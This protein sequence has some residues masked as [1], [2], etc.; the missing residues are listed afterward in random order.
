MTCRLQ[1]IELENFRG[2]A[3]TRSLDLD[4]D[5]VL[6]RGDNGSGKTSLTDG[7]LWLLTGEL[8]HL[9]ERVKG[10][11]QTH[12]AIANRYSDGAS[13]VA[14]T[15]VTPQASWRFER[16]GNA[17]SS[18]LRG[19]RDGQPVE[20]EE[21]LAHA[22]GDGDLRDFRD[23]VGTWGVLRQDAIRSVL[24]TGGAALH[25]RM[26]SVIGLSEVSRFRAACR[27][28][29][30]AAAQTRRSAETVLAAAAK[31]L[32]A[33]RSAQRKGLP[34]AAANSSLLAV[35]LVESAAPVAEDLRVEVAGVASLEDLVELGRQVTLLRDLAAA[36]ADAQDSYV[37]SS[38]QRKDAVATVQ[39]EFNEAAKQA[40]E[41]ESTST[42]I[43][44]LAELALNLL[45]NQCPVCDQDIDQAAVRSKLQA[46]LERN[47]LRLVAAS[48]ARAALSALSRRLREAQATEQQVKRATEIRD[49]RLSTWLEALNAVGLIRMLRPPRADSARLLARRLD[50]LRAALQALYAEERATTELDEVRLAA[51]VTA[52]E[53][54]EVVAR[55]ALSTAADRERRL[56]SLETGTQLAADR[57]IAEWLQ[58]LEPSFAEVFDRLAPHPT[59]K[60]LRAKQD[61]F[62]NKNQIVPEVVDAERGVRANPLLVY[63]EGQLNTVALSYFLGLALNATEDPLGFMILDDPLQAMDVL[64][65]LGFADLCRRL[66]GQRQ[67]LITTHDR[68]YADLLGRKLAPREV[69]Q[70]TITHEFTSW[71]A[72]GPVVET[73]RSSFSGF[74]RKLQA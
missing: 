16:S 8:P 26:S 39:S 68:R 45:T 67:L 37:Q 40:E 57:I 34:L 10:L 52:A 7:I 6:V 71:S 48:E 70:S 65:V 25:D 12:D 51:A 60:L 41:L 69:G 44:R 20:G 61:V 46:D 63:S 53:E 15:F 22:L 35:R 24:D 62:Y 49:A 28:A 55:A 66:R 64:G 30:A 74:G 32:E 72:A 9:L 21:A 1:L 13:R 4:A 56:K 59:F 19:Y 50:E 23:A 38:A 29:V 17:K 31:T 47:R 27:A 73:S 54:Q 5:V 2:F 33:A 18:T 3:D 36:A 11:R 58:A 42:D 43:E 14:L